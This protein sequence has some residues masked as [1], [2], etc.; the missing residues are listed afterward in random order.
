MRPLSL[1]MV[2]WHRRRPISNRQE[3][4]MDQEIIKQ[5]ALA[6]AE[7]LPNPWVVL[8]V[9]TALVII[10]A[11]VGAYFSEYLKTRGKNLV[12]RFSQIEG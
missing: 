2:R 12:A 11:G 1:P 4:E 10:A 8:L 7:R 5:I 6:I 9:Q 3:A